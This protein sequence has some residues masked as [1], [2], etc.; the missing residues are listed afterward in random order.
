VPW[1]HNV[2]N[3]DVVAA[4]DDEACMALMRLFN[5]PE[6]RAHLGGRGR[7]SSVDQARPAGHLVHLQ[8]AD[9]DQDREVLRA[10]TAAT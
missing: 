7:P 1:I 9:R 6:G 4:I 5:E 3:T 2:R 10:W 8:P